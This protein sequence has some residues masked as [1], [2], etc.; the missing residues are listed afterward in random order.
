MTVTEAAS[1]KKKDKSNLTT[2][3]RMLSA[4]K[5]RKREEKI[6]KLSNDSSHWSG[7]ENN[8][9]EE[10]LNSFISKVRKLYYKGNKK[11]FKQFM[12]DIEELADELAE[13]YSGCDGR[14]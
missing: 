11:S 8:E 10:D 5:K 13:T 4:Y 9:L 1:T 7:L 6:G 14:I 12:S 2:V 3:K